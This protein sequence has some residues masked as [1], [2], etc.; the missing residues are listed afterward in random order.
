VETPAVMRKERILLAEDN[1]VNQRV[2]LGNLRKLG[3]EADVVANGL[4]V[5]DAM[6]IKRY[7]IILMDCH[8]PELDGYEV[9]REIRQREKNGRH[10]WIIAMTANVMVGDREKC[11]DAGM[12]DYVS[13]PLRRPELRTA[14]ERFTVDH[15]A[16]PAPV[17]PDEML[18][19]FDDDGVELAELIELFAASA[20]KSIAQMHAAVEKND[21]AALS[22]AAH[23][24]KGSCGNLGKFP[25]YEICVQLE[26]IGRSGN[27]NG[28]GDLVVSAENELRRLID[29]LR[30]YRRNK[31]TP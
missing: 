4:E 21:A 11:L 6:E 29:T 17:A 2:A 27:L 12:D 26:Q 13:K 14:L 19:N 24:L 23:T 22:F 20:P 5:L 3:Y 31:V 9:T 10:V 15:N 18:A 25:L 16:T 1:P 8:M 7:D 30:S 28:V